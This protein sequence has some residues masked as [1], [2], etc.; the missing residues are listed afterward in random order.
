M[1]DATLPEAAGFS[2]TVED[3]IAVLVWDMPG[4]SMNVFTMEALDALGALVDDLAARDDVTGVVVTSGKASFSGGADLTVLQTLLGGYHA[5]VAEGDAGQ[6]NARLLEESSRMS[7]IYRRLETCGKPWVCALNGTAAGGATELALACHRRIAADDEAIRISLPEVKVGLFP[8]AGGTQRVMRLAEPQGGL[9]FLLQGREL[10]PRQAK[11]LGLIDEIVP[12]G[13]LLARAKAALAEGVDPKKPWD[14]S[15]FRPPLGRIYS[16]QG[17]QLFSAANAIYRRETYD[18][19]PAAR[20][21]LQSVYEG[22]LLPIDQALRVESRWF[23][24][25]LT[26]RE[27]A[28][29][30]RSL[31][32]SMQELKKGA[33]RP[34]VAKSRLSTVGVVGAGF[35]G[36]GIASVAAQAGLSVVLIDQDL[37]AAERARAKIGEGLADRVKKGRMTQAEAEAVLARIAPSADMAALAPADLVVEAVFEDRGVKRQVIEAAGAVL[38]ETAVLASNTSTLPITSLAKDAARP[39]R[40]I[41]LHF[42]SP[43]ERMML[44]EVIV[45]EETGPE[46]LAVALDFVKAIRKTP[47]VVNDSR[48]FYVNRCVIRYLTEAHL[49]LMEGVPAPMI[50]TVARMAGMPVGPLA[51]TDEVAI[52]LVHRILKASKADLG[53]GAVDPAQ[54]RLISAMVET[55]G[56]LGRKNGKGFYDYLDGGKKRLWP[57]LGT[58]TGPSVP[59]DDI[60]VETLKTRLLAIQALE[61]IRCLEEGVVTDVREADVGS[62]LGYGFAPFTGGTL[63]YVDGIG[64]GAFLEECRD[65]EAT[66]GERFAA[67]ALLVEMAEKGETFYGRFAP[68]ADRAA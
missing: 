53:D 32:V 39:D 62:I 46:A 13:E 16:P 26:T 36:A 61:A 51:L 10:S 12:A 44:V 37:A 48:G 29:M 33:R 43:V 21:I 49:M 45:G 41:G 9:Q 22:L 68:P 50:E 34:D 65:L 7:R 1:S 25:V 18:N 40:F 57:D 52:D 54:D 59:A 60:S 66:F 4:R 42:F 14:R 11:G 8:G 63:S 31:F 35:M 27:A 23:A 58:I 55:H 67:P 15:G 17:M 30:I 64:A 6:A 56:R 47:I 38:S 19:Y 20:A 5:L 28:V 24:H 2:L 3:G